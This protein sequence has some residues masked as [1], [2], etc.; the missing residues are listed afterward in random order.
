MVEMKHLLKIIMVIVLAGSIS[1]CSELEEIEERGFVVGAAYDIVKKKKSNPIMKGTYQMV[2]PSK[3]A[4]QGGQG[5]G[6]SENYINVS[7]KADSVFEQI[8]IIAKKLVEHYFSAYTSHYFSDKL[9]AN[10]YVLQNT[11][12]VYFRDHEMRRN[13]RL[14]VS[15]KNAESILKQS[16][17]PE[18]L[19]AQYI[20]ML[21]EHPP[22]NAQMIE[23]ARIGEVQGK[24]IADRSFALPLLGL[25]KQGVQMEGA[26][27]IRGKDN[28]CVGTLSGE[29]TLGMNYV[30]GKKLEV[31]L[32]FVKRIS[33]LHMKFISC[34]ERSKCLLKMLQNRSLIFI[35]PQ[36]AY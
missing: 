7:A 6:D 18:N 3:L 9:L 24:M 12:D 21:A 1:G 2:L 23:A 22:K 33:S 31:S 10:P 25:T 5:D 15:K 8:R 4:Q 36:K 30:I 34:A 11:L 32:L 26:A 29:Q 20:D 16:A 13:I 27:L 35:C 28:K 14:F 19:P 17:K